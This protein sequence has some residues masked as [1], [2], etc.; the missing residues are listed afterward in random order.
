ME[1]LL[2]LELLRR[3]EQPRELWE[4][5]ERRETELTMIILHGPDKIAHV[6]WG[7]YQDVMYAPFDEARLLSTAE[8]WEGPIMAPAPI[9]LGSLV[10]PYLEADE[11]LG[12]LL[13]IHDYD[14]VV[15]VSDHGMTRNPNPGLAGSH[16]R[17]AIEAH[18]GILAIHGPGVERGAWLGRV[19]VLDVAPTLAYLLDLP[20]A[21]DLPG[22]VLVEA[23]TAERL[24]LWAPDGKIVPTWE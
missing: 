11:W 1:S 17:W 4:L 13:S 10:G 22:R 15:F 9:G 24:A 21:Q 23:F 14:Y 8:A 6:A 3:L 7:L 5:W 20:V 18:I 19:S 2:Q 12:Q 16:N